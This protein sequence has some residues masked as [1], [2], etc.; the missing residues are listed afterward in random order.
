MATDS[1]EVGHAGAVWTTSPRQPAIEMIH[2]SG[3]RAW[4]WMFPA[5][6]TVDERRY[7][8]AAKLYRTALQYNQRVSFRA[9]VSWVT[10]RLAMLAIRKGDDRRGVRVLAAVHE[11]GAT[12]LRGNAPELTYER[13]RALGDA[14]AVLG[15]T[16]FAAEW[17]RG[18]A[19][20]LENASLEAVRAERVDRAE[21][22][23]LGP[24]T[25]RQLDI[26]RLIARGLT[27]RQIAEQL[28]VSPHTVERH[29]ENIL[30]RL[31]LSSRTEIAV[32]MVERARG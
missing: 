23:S 30:D 26:A 4:G 28:V 32:W 15:D 21:S 12:T 7:Q 8:E 18:Q 6:L 19:L 5:D 24:L 2:R 11:I 22:T 14:R 31:R 27:N 29:V 9:G 13:R 17:T 1:R 10:Q 20:T 3:T 16:S 25:R